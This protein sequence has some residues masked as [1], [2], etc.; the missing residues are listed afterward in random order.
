LWNVQPSESSS[1]ITCLAGTRLANI[2]ACGTT[3]EFLM[4]DSRTG[5]QLWQAEESGVAVTRFAGG[6][7]IKVATADLSGSLR[8]YEFV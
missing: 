8:L 1:A 3:D 2:I 5:E 7:S 4:L 6:N